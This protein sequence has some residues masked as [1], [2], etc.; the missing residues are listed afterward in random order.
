MAQLLNGR[1]QHIYSKVARQY[2]S[3]I[4]KL[5]FKAAAIQKRDINVSPEAKLTDTEKV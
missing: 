4:P 3:Q 5:H 1:W 2:I